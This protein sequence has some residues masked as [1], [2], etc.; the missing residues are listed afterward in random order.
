M[1]NVMHEPLLKG[2]SARRLRITHLERGSPA[3]TVRTIRFTKRWMVNYSSTVLYSSGWGG[4]GVVR[5]VGQWVV[6][7]TAR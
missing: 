2:D 3:C 5:V 1:P 4:G 7:T 6:L